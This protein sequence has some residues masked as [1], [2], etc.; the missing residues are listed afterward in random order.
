VPG[1]GTEVRIALP[2]ESAH[3]RTAESTRA[4]NAGPTEPPIH[5]RRAR[6]ETA[7][8]GRA[9]SAEAAGT[10]RRPVS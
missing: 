6:T 7:I 5:A 2:F 4:A 8:A 3:G 1:R 10:R 9:G